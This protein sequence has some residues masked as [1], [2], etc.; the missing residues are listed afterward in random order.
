MGTSYWLPA[1]ITALAL[2]APA[3]NA[4]DFWQRLTA[5]C[6]DAYEGELLRAPA[7]DTSFEGRWL[8]MHVRACEE[9]P[10]PHPV[11]GGR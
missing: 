7:G 1:A 9:K 3:A 11:R 2:A 4:D 5:L 8:V 6:G 10:H